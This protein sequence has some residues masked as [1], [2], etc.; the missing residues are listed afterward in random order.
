[1]A[2]KKDTRGKA[3]SRV[4]PKNGSKAYAEHPETK[5]LVEIAWCSNHM[6]YERTNNDPVVVK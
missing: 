5:E 4:T 3:N 2:R 6:R 1:M